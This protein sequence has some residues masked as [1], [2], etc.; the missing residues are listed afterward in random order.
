MDAV[1]DEMRMSDYYHADNYSA[2]GYCAHH[3]CCQNDDCYI[4]F[5]AVRQHSDH[6][7]AD[8]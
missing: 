3:D 4:D 7:Q 6:K 1:V 2:A 8:D 5:A